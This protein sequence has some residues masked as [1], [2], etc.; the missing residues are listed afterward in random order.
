MVACGLLL[1]VWDSNLLFLIGQGRGSLAGY[2]WWIYFQAFL[3]GRDGVNPDFFSNVA[4]FIAGAGG[5]YFVTPDAA[6]HAVPAVAIRTLILSGAG[7]LL[8]RLATGFRPILSQAWWL[9]ASQV[10]ISMLC[11]LGTAQYSNT[12]PRER[13]L[14]LLL[15]SSCYCYSDQF[16]AWVLC[17]EAG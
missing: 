10:G 15:I 16:F 11:I 7:V 12:G 1:P 6:I 3:F 9:L 14:A 17:T 4:D 13:R 5:I 2:D 8:F